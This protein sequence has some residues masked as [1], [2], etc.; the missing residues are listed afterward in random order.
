MHYFAISMRP[1]STNPASAKG[2]SRGSWTFKVSRGGGS[3]QSG[4][5]SKFGNWRRVKI[6][7]FSSSFWNR[8]LVGVALSHCYFLTSRLF[9]ER[10][11]ARIVDFSCFSW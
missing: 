4:V 3:I 1:R 8:S 7:S 10:K 6:A 5:Q 11:V 9:G 2:R